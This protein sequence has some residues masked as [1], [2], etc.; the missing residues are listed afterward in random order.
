MMQRTPQPGLGFATNWLSQGDDGGWGDETWDGN[1]WDDGGGGGGWDDDYGVGYDLYV[2]GGILTPDQWDTVYYSDPLQRGYQWDAE[3]N[4]WVNPQTGAILVSEDYATGDTTLPWCQNIF[5]PSGGGGQGD[6]Q[7]GYDPLMGAPMRY[8]DNLPGYCPGGTYHPLNDPYACVPF[9]DDP[10]QR[11]QAQ[12]QAQ[13]QKQAQA[14]P[15]RSFPKQQYQ[16]CPQGY[17]PVRGPDG[18][19]YCVLASALPKD[20]PQPNWLLWALIAAGVIVAFSR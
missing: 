1:W 6:G 4:T 18:K 19:I 5:Q 12:K 16:N 10:V 2:N 7:T 17:Q 13:Q 8:G 11:Q 14:Q 3:T 15:Q 9:P 20:K